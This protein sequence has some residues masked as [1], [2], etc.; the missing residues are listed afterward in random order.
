MQLYMLYN[1]IVII[2]KSMPINVLFNLKEG[3]GDEEVHQ[4]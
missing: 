3:I 2:D 4:A 1:H